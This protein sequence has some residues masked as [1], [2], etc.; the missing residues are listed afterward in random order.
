MPYR[1]LARKTDLITQESGEELLV[2]DLNYNK[3]H[4]LNKTSA[5][6][7]KLCVGRFEVH[8]IANKLSKKLGAPITEEVVWLALDQLKKDG[9]LEEGY[10]I[11]Q[12]FVG[13]T[14]REIIRK[15]GFAS[16]VTLPIVSSIVAPKAIMG[17][18]VVPLGETCTPA[19]NCMSGVIC[20]ATVSGTIGS[21]DTPTGDRCCSGAFTPTLYIVG[22]TFCDPTCSG[23]CCNN[24]FIV[25]PPDPAC[26]AQLTCLCN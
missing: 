8:E 22:S 1:P 15:V 16:A 2:Y 10:E 3:A 14:R 17:Q 11:D 7:W 5:E 4:C 25:S 6:V 23:S 12:A 21:P 18:S 24:S 9:L 13:L 20:R 26:G 19:S